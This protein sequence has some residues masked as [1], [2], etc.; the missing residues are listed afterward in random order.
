MDINKIAAEVYKSVDQ[1]Y[2]IPR[3]FSDI[4]VQA[5]TEKLKEQLIDAAKDINDQTDKMLHEA[6]DCTPEKIIALTYERVLLNLGLR[7][8]NTVETP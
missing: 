3:F 4:M 5:I 8:E 7:N 2:P 6:K 1:T